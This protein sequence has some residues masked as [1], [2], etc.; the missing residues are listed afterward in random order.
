MF[1]K[2]GLCN[3]LKLSATRKA[4][5]RNVLVSLTIGV[6]GFS[7]V[8]VAANSI[9]PTNHQDDDINYRVNTRNPVV[10]A[11]VMGIHAEQKK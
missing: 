7:S 11:L 8:A 1:K 5:R 9:N 2:P 3:G 10:D 6:F 4:M